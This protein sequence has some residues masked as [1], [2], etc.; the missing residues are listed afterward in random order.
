MIGEGKKTELDARRFHPRNSPF[1]SGNKSLEKSYL[2]AFLMSVR[3][4]FEEKK[5]LVAVVAIT[6]L[7]L[8]SSNILSSQEIP[9]KGMV[10]VVKT[11]YDNISGLQ[12]RWAS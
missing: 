7:Q 3:V 2:I 11:K 4:V 1:F 8:Y 12:H 5:I 10:C 6:L 9:R